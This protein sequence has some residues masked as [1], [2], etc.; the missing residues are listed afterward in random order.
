MSCQVACV[1]QGCFGKD[2]VVGMWS[3]MAAATVVCSCC[4]CSCGCGSRGSC[5]GC[6]EKSVVVA[7]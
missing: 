6:C 7:L 2:V 3:L 1:I 4:Q 5:G